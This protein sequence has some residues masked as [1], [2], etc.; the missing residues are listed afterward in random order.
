MNLDQ[1]RVKRPPNRA[2]VDA[3]KFAMLMDLI[4]VYIA[5]N[6]Q[7]GLANNVDHFNASRI[8]DA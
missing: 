5:D 6:K 4:R 1:L 2:A 7:G 3:H 8:L